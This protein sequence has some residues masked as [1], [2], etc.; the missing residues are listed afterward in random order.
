MLSRLASASSCCGACASGIVS[1]TVAVGSAD[2]SSTLP[3]AA[4]FVESGISSAAG[5]GSPLPKRPEKKLET[6]SN[7]PGSSAVS[8]A[9]APT[10]PDSVSRLFAEALSTGA[11]GSSADVS[12]VLVDSSSTGGG[13]ATGAFRP[14]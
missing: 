12:R 11:V 2:C 7:M 9:S 10:S 4:G 5:S 6:P 3:S 14:C 1:G 13:V 8:F